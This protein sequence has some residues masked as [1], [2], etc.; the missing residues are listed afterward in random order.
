ML[1]GAPK[2]LHQPLK[3]VF[4]CPSQ[5]EPAGTIPTITS[6]AWAR[7]SLMPQAGMCNPCMQLRAG[8]RDVHWLR[9]CVL[10]GALPRLQHA[11]VY[12]QNSANPDHQAWWESKT[13]EA[14]PGR[15]SVTPVC[16]PGQR[17][18]KKL[19]W[20]SK[21]KTSSLGFSQWTGIFSCRL[22]AALPASCIGVSRP[23]EAPAG[24]GK[25]TP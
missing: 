9:L 8:N 1:L 22:V 25:V 16:G 21:D 12:P 14:A 23:H 6:P 11:H 4:F 24:R 18:G 2:S 15:L 7:R 10:G 17:L 5:W 19:P 20:S 13:A 3:P